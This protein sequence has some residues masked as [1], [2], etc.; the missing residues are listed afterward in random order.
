M[1]LLVANGFQAESLDGGV[2]AWVA[3]G[4]ELVRSNGEPGE[5]LAPQAEA[6]Y[7]PPDQAETR[8]NVMEVI[9]GLAERYGNREPT[10]EEAKAFMREWLTKKGKSPEE[11]ERTLADN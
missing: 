6:E 3:A 10:D 2:T 5:V 11:I 8:D 9:F 7:L 1:D 4:K